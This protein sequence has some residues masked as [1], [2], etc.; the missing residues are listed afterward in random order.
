M[1]KKSDKFIQ[2]LHSFLTVYL[3]KQRNSSPHTVLAAKQVWNMLL[4]YICNTTGKKAETV[5]FSDVSRVVV[6]GFLDA[7]EKRWDGHRELATIGWESSVLSSDTQQVLS[8]HSH[9]I[10]KS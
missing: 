5:V 6:L 4:N 8:Q 10:W 3:P 9:T 1:K 2:L 7:R